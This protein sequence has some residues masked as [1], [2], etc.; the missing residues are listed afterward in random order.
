MSSYS[1]N[2]QDGK[3]VIKSSGDLVTNLI[4]VCHSS[5]CSNFPSAHITPSTHWVAKEKRHNKEEADPQKF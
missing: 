2:E 4:A 3:P 1:S 5:G